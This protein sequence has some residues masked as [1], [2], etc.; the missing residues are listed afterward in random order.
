[1]A[2]LVYILCAGTSVFCAFLLFRSY[3]GQRSRLLLLSTIC[4]LGLAVN[5]IVL[6]VDLIVFP[7]NDLRVFRTVVAFVSIL[8]FLFGLIWE[9]R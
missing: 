6:L 1:M 9:A 2:E 7:E 3:R 5:S 8:V 4:F